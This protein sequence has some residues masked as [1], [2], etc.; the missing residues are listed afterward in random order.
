MREYDRLKWA[1][2][3]GYKQKH[4]IG[5]CCGYIHFISSRN[6]GKQFILKHNA[7]IRKGNNINI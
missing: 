2:F 1:L 6:V 7:N 5:D 4:F 3:C